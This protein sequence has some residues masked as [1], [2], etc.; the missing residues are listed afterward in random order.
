MELAHTLC[1]STLGVCIQAMHQP[2]QVVTVRKYVCVCV[3]LCLQAM[4]EL[5]IHL[6]VPPAGFT[7][8][9]F[10]SLFSF[11]LQRKQQS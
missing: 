11:Q 1:M 6:G 2:S 4:A 10:G 8:E 7:W 3:C 5:W 9:H